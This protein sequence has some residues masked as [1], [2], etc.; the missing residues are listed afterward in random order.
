MKHLQQLQW[1]QISCLRQRLVLVSWKWFNE[2]NFAEFGAIHDCYFVKYDASTNQLD[3]TGPEVGS[4]TTAGLQNIEED[5]ADFIVPFFTGTSS[6]GASYQDN[7]GH[8]LTV[9]I[10]ECFSTFTLLATLEFIINKVLR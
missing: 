1:K 2:C 10:K 3:L 5:P 8:Y 9:S 7:M 4:D 6:D